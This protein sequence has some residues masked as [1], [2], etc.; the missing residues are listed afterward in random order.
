MFQHGTQVG[1]F[2][3]RA[4]D[5]RDLLQQVAQIATAKNH[6]GVTSI[7]AGG[8][9]YA[10]GDILEVS[11]GTSTHKTRIRVLTVSGGVVLT[12]AIESGGAY[13]A[14]PGFPASTLKVT[15]AGDDACTVTLD[16]LVDTGWTTLRNLVQLG[17]TK[18]TLVAG[19]TGY[20]V[21]DTVTL[22]SGTGTQATFNVDAET[23]GIIDPGGIS[24]VTSGEYTAAPDVSAGATTSGG[25]GSGAT[26]S[27]VTQGRVGEDELILE[28]E[29]GGTDE[30]TMGMRTYQF[31]TS[32]DNWELAGMTG[33]ADSLPF[34]DQPNISEGRFD[35]QGSVTGGSYLPLQNSDMN[36]WLSVTTR[37]IF[38]IVKVGS[39][40]A[41]CHLGF[42]NPFGTTTELPYPA[43]VCGST[44]HYQEAFNSTSINYSSPIDP[45]KQSNTA[46]HRG[47]GF[48]RLASGQWAS[49]ANS[50]K[51]SSARDALHEFV[52]YPAGEPVS[53]DNPTGPIVQDPDEI[54]GNGPI[55][56]QDI[57]PNSGTPGVPLARL[58]PSLLTTG[59][60]PPL[61]PTTLILS[62]TVLGQGIKGEMDGVY[63]VTAA[64]DPTAV[65]EDDF[66]IG[67][68]R[69]LMFQSGNRT[70]LF[71]FFTIK[72]A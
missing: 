68:Q 5:Y 72:E 69:Y 43:Y 31:E 34:E 45:I 28:G 71:T 9:G 10:V 25:G 54:V 40:Y 21:N 55:D 23:G 29:G 70:E 27:A 58:Y 53:D 35:D 18:G 13:S 65:S 56:W 14:S 11:G 7:G 48:Y 6:P 50:E 59:D 39:N 4:S 32:A 42:L 22:N 61:I 52:V 49:V 24:L 19:G 33:Y 46:N 57:I 67:D 62:S 37:R 38:L 17:V 51:N 47:P 36:F 63:W 8:T 41:S 2:D 3:N 16:A 12:A 15:G 44:S 1:S 64:T 20:S 66:S 26:I 30:I 60:A